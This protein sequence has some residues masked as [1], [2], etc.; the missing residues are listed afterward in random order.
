M[1]QDRVEK[2]KKNLVFSYITTFAKTL[3]S[4]ILRTIFIKILSEDYLGVNSLFTD[5]LNIL[6]FAELGIGNVMNF[7]LYKPVADN[8]KEKIKSLMAFYKKAYTTIAFVIAGLGLALVPFLDK[9]INNPNN[10]EH[11]TTF[12]LIYLYNTVVTYFVSYKHSIANAEQ[13][14]YIVSIINTLSYLATVLV[15]IIALVCFRNYLIYLLSASVVLTIRLIIESKYFDKKYPLLTEKNIEKLDDKELKT[16]NKNV[17][18]LIIH[19]LSDVCVNQTDSLLTSM[20]SNLAM[21]GLFS[22]YKMIMNAISGYIS[23]IFTS[24]VST[25]GNIVAVEKR[26]TQLS[27]FNS[28]NFIN[29]WIYGFSC[30]AFLFLLKPSI[31]ILWGEKYTIDQYYVFFI[32]LN[33]YIAG[34][35]TAYCNFKAANGSFTDDRYLVLFSAILNLVISVIL[36]KTIGLVGIYVGTT[37]TY[38]FEITVRPAMSYE[39]FTVGKVRD[40]YFNLLK[41]FLSVVLAGIVLHLLF[42]YLPLGYDLL[43]YICKIIIVAIIPNVIFFLLYRKTNEFKYFE[44]IALSRLRHGK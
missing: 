31:I 15:Q 43:G 22:N 26:E 38:L 12:Y 42:K 21:V 36:A 39:K 24:T 2:V 5:V 34:Q 20:F 3:A 23:T 28:Y 14:N 10:I 35:L 27:L 17:R 18:G 33:F 30:L 16:I 37:I 13:N 32:C 11:I 44:N 29:F 7:A 41:Y 19:K 40:F 25:L 1:A 9:I 4:F 8:D 6:S